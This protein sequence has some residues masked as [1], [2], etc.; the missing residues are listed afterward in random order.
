MIKYWY[1]WRGWVDNIK[2]LE[3]WMVN[4]IHSFRRLKTLQESRQYCKA[5]NDRKETEC[6]Y[7][8][9]INFRNRNYTTLPNNW[10]DIYISCHNTKSW[11][12]IHKVRKQ[13]LKRKIHRKNLQYE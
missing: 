4:D 11:K 13:Y 8:V 1:N 3:F 7:N 5:I 10:D 6:D 12:K 9:T 2:T